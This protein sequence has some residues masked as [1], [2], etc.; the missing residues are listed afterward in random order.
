MIGSAGFFRRPIGIC[1]FRRPYFLHGWILATIPDYVPVY[2]GNLNH[3][4]AFAANGLYAR[5]AGGCERAAA[6]FFA[7]ATLVGYAAKSRE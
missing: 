1:K 6:R 2:T 4:D 5:V 7:Y 3:N